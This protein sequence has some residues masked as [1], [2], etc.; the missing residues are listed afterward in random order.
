MTPLPRTPALQDAACETPFLR[1]LN[2]LLSIACLVT[3][4]DILATFRQQTQPELQQQQQ[5]QMQQSGQHDDASRTRTASP[6]GLENDPKAATAH[7]GALHHAL[8][9][10]VY[11]LHWFFSFLY[12]TDV[13]SLYFLLLAQLQVRHRE[14]APDIP[15]P[16]DTYDSV[17][18]KVTIGAGPGGASRPCVLGGVSPGGRI[19]ANDTAEGGQSGRKEGGQS[20]RKEGGRSVYAGGAEACTPRAAPA[21]PPASQQI[22]DA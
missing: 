11:P 5:Q 22:L 8:L 17:V 12:Y 2:V 16:Y 6:S 18:R 1:S 19:L 7:V 20:G 14:I 10:A 3:L 15:V 21:R 13:A 9:L 4:R